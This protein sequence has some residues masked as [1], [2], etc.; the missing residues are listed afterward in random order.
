M[1]IETFKE[2]IL[3]DVTFNEYLT[4]RVVIGKV[5]K[6][7]RPRKRLVNRATKRPVE[8]L[9][10]GARKALT[11]R[12]IEKPT[13]S[14]RPNVQQRLVNRTKKALTK[15]VKSTLGVSNQRLLRLI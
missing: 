8:R 1:N 4:Y 11:K 12:P 7:L 6:E 10:K 5:A 2:L 13:K 14:Q 9:V 3:A 15:K